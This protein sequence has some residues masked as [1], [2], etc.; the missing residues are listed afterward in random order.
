M[1]ARCAWV[2]IVVLVDTT[3]WIDLLREV[4]S[5]AVRRL[6]ALLGTNAAAVA[7][8][9]VQEILQGAANARALERLRNHCMSLPLLAPTDPLATY[10]QA[11]ALYARCRWQGITPRSP[12]DCLIAAIAVE[13]GVPLLHDDRDFLALA[14]VEP[15]LILETL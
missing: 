14:R 4:D 8:A 5:P 6:R 11:G 13:Y 15:R 12:H 7:P 10:A 1:C 3:V 2:W 9:I